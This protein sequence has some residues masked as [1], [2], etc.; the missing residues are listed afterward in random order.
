VL[1]IGAYD[2]TRVLLLS[3]HPGAGGALE[4]GAALEDEGATVGSGGVLPALQPAATVTAAIAARTAILID[5]PA[6]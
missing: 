2:W 3:S 5:T 1:W 6:A 4:L